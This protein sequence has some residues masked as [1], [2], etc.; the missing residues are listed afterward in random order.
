M[1]MSFNI[2]LDWVNQLVWALKPHGM[3]SSPAVINT[4]SQLGPAFASA[5]HYH[6][7]E[8]TLHS[9]TLPGYPAVTST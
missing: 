8:L 7:S 6:T 2:L 3:I 1:V 9:D 5:T 4:C